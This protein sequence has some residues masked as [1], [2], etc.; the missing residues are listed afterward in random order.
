M[1]SYRHGHITLAFDQCSKYS[2]ANKHT[3]L[4]QEL[5]SYTRQ[6]ELI[7]L[8][9]VTLFVIYFFMFITIAVPVFTVYCGILWTFSLIFFIVCIVTDGEKVAFADCMS[10]PF[11]A[12]VRDQGIFAP[13]PGKHIV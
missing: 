5:Q 1:K 2:I 3:L 10:I 9:G 13:M 6:I 4:S 12:T 11:R 8:V 7:I